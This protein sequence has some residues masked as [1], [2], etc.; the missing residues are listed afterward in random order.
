MT[1]PLSRVYGWE[2]ARRNRRWDR[3]E[4]VTRLDRP[5]VSIG[6]LSAGGTGKTPM[7]RWAVGALQESGHRPAVAMRGYKAEPGQPSDE[8][9]EHR[10][11]LPGV[12]VVARPDRAAG[13]QDLFATPEGAQVD[14]VVLDDG[15][16]HR[17]LARD[18]DIVLVDASRPPDRD[19]LLPLGYLREP[20]DS[21][22]RAQACVLTHAELV[23]P[24]RLADLADLVRTFLPDGS[25]V[26]VAEH[27]WTR[28]RRVGCSDEPVVWLAGRRVVAVCA[29]G[30]PEAFLTG[31]EQA[32]AGVAG[33]LCLPDHDAFGPRTVRRL[34]AMVESCR[35]E[36]VVMTA[37]DLTKLDSWSRGCPVP[38]V[39]PELG[40]GWR[41]GEDA[42]RARIAA[43][44]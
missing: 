42:L 3:G 24:E 38:V 23:G 7:V 36:A 26:A 10:E 33:S 20:L 34:E 21:L 39:V 43:I 29:I 31:L 5:V 12:P 35:P 6:N 8:E 13:L 22:R 37:K 14:C 44:L 11:A 41:S 19:A 2:V 27:R 32:G 18:L 25:P 17:R 15:F 1:G 16:Q 4:G 30:H 9:R 28:L 40:M